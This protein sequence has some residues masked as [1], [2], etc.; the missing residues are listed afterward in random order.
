MKPALSTTENRP[1]LLFLFSDQQRYDTL[2]C[3][4]NEQIQMPNLN[5]LAAQSVVF[6]H[7]HCTQALCTPSRGSLM[8]G[9]W[10]HTHGAYN[11]N[12]PLNADAPCLPELLPETTRDQYR[13][14]YMGKWHLGDELYAQHGYDEWISVEDFYHGKGANDQDAPPRHSDYHRFLVDNGF[15]PAI[16]DKGPGFTRDF[17]ARI[18]EPYGKPHFT[19][20]QAS[21]F[22]H[23]NENR[24]WLLTV[25]FLEPHPPFQS[26]RDA[27]YDPA[28]MK[29]P[30]NCHREVGNDQPACLKDVYEQCGAASKAPPVE[31]L[32]D[33]MARYWGL[34]SL[35]DTHVGRILKALDETG[36]RDNTIVVFTSDHGEMMGAHGL[37]HKMFMFKESTRVP[38]TVQL[39]G[40]RTPGRITGPVS[41]IDLVP[42]LL[43]LLGESEAGA[44]LPGASLA[45][46]CRQAA[47]GET[48]SSEEVA[49]PCVIEWNPRPQARKHP[50]KTNVRTLIT[51]RGERYSHYFDGEREYYDLNT[52]PDETRNLAHD[53]HDP[54]AQHQPRMQELEQQLANWQDAAADT[55]P[56]LQPA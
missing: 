1:N 16:A 41:Q 52:D 21:D 32:P 11:N 35:V 19:A 27:Q 36:Q 43:E 49:S 12:V 28:D 30:A 14:A 45:S 8:T 7:V 44:H 48:V 5:R 33:L 39:P 31:Q 9:L 3:Y 24:P 25:N 13:T 37:F 15:V 20:T 56:R 51:H 6:D 18:P 46:L 42:T 53:S 22:I 40:Q 55:A 2:A 17:A 29:L 47:Q 4:G 38:M 10:P 26:P 23:R 54:H 34:N 50:F